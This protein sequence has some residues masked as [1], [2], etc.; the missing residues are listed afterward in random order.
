MRINKTN[1]NMTIS[2]NQIFCDDTIISIPRA[3]DA[4][5]PE[6]QVLKRESEMNQFAI[7]KLMRMMIFIVINN[8]ILISKKCEHSEK[9]PNRCRH[10]YPRNK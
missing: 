8:I 9:D 10:V 3:D 4:Q 2:E 6:T 5:K 1:C 7:E